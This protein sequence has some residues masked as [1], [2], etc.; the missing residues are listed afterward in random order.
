MPKRFLIAV[1]LL[2]LCSQA[3]AISA[4]DAVN[5]AT[6]QNNFLYSGE[7]A[8]VYPNVRIEHKGDDYWVITILSGGD[9]KGFV[10]VLDKSVPELPEGSIA[11]RE[12]IKT[13]YVLRYERELNES[14]GLQGLWL[15]DAKNAKFFSDLGQDLKNEKIDLTTV[16][17][18]LAGFPLLQDDLDDLQ[19]M[20]D[21]MFPLAEDIG[22]QVFDTTSFEN[23]FLARPDTNR[24][25]LFKESFLDSFELI[26]QLEEMRTG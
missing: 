12:L 18:S 2:L 1:A 15:F 9:L 16:K 7:A 21:Q 3:F 20:L 14:S 13:A 19:L 10:P 8:E 24:L 6:K 17:T 26:G 22:V 5:F 25:Q 4:Q 23:S 11:R